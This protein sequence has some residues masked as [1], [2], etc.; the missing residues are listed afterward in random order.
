MFYIA[1]FFEIK[2]ALRLRQLSDN[3]SQKTT[4]TALPSGPAPKPARK[5]SELPFCTEP[6]GSLQIACHIS[7]LWHFPVI[8]LN[9]HAQIR[10][11]SLRRAGPFSKFIWWCGAYFFGGF[12]WEI[13]GFEPVVLDIDDRVAQRGFWVNLGLLIADLFVFRSLFWFFDAILEST[14]QHF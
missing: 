3:H 10:A 14:R 1:I 13:G 11:T 4:P 7:L 5:R 12:G 8:P 2:E 6:A 9:D